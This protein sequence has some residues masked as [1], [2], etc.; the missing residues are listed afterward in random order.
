MRHQTPMRRRRQATMAR[1][2]SNGDVGLRPTAVLVFNL[3]SIVLSDAGFRIGYWV[4]GGNLSYAQKNG[5]SEGV[6]SDT[7]E[8]YTQLCRRSEP[9][10]GENGLSLLHVYL[11]FRECE[12]T[13]P[14]CKS[15][16]RGPSRTVSEAID[17]HACR[18]RV[19]AA[20]DGQAAT[21]EK[22]T[23]RHGRTMSMLT[24]TLE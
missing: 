11:S 12:P 3:L 8:D 2:E 1:V 7:E 18:A 24:L 23:N 4:L 6:R 9:R 19:A 14:A 15:S 17:K 16:R 21:L 10:E 13:V 5:T 20:T 22:R